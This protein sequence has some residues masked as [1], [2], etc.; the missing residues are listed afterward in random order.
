MKRIQ[1]LIPARSALAIALAASATSTLTQGAL[2][3]DCCRWELRIERTAITSDNFTVELYAHIP[4]D[5]YAFNVGTLDLMTDGVQWIDI[6]SCT[7]GG[8]ASDP[9]TIVG[10]DVMGIVVG[11]VHVPPAILA[12]DANPILVWCGEFEATDGAAFRTIETI[13][14][15]FRYYTSTATSERAECDPA[16]SIRTV[17][18][19]PLVVDDWLA[20]PFEGTSA[21]TSLDALRIINEL[22]RPGVGAAIAAEGAPWAP[23]T[24]FEHHVDLDDL[25]PGAPVEMSWFPW[26]T[27]GG[28]TTERLSATMTR[29][30]ATG[31]P[32]TVEISL[33]F[34]EVGSPRVPL[35][36]ELDGR[37]IA[38]PILGAGQS[39]RLV[40][41]CI[42][43]TFCYVLDTNDQ[44]VLVLKCENP[45]DFLIGGERF[46]ADTV[47]MDPGIGS[48][49]VD[50]LDR[51]E[52]RS[53]A[54]SLTI[55]G[56]GFVD[57]TGTA[58]RADCDDNG[59]LDIFDFLCFQN[60]FAS[61]DPA[62]D[63]DGDGRLT[64]FDFL[65]FQNEFSQG[66]D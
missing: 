42:E 35:T 38:T 31:E 10:D 13:T 22:G 37:E 56:E 46:R 9:G 4:D 49:G 7:L 63:F 24:R 52:V 21:Q 45:F 16:E 5:A 14:D 47:K 3:D 57:G 44:L 55:G 6:D 33:N 36:L 64:I 28:F 2:A 51:V 26:W 15:T 40:D 23:G 59:R 18:V 29:T 32:P 1:N 19:G 17:F 11:Q 60:L 54:T 27:C 12:D 43:L 30:A 50:G 58:C 39:F 25:A 66:C 34:E 62:A 20:V 61:G 65:A 41:P 8:G 53:P 48:G